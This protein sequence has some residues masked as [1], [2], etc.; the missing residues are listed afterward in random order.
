MTDTPEW[1][2]CI[3]EMLA[4]PGVV[5]VLGGSDSGK[6]TFCTELANAA[7]AAEVPCAVVD[8]DV[9]QS[10]IGPPGTIGLGIVES[11]ITTTH[12]LRPRRL[13]FVGDVT[14]VG[15][16]LQCVV[17]VK[18]LVDE[19]LHRGAKLV[20]VD[21]TGLIRGTVGARLKTYKIDLVAPSYLVAIQSA[22]EAEHVLR[23][24]RHR[25]G[26][27]I[28]RLQ[29]AAQ[30]RA[31]SQEMRSG[32]RRLRLYEHFRMAERHALRLDELDCWG[33]WLNTGEP[34]QWQEARKLEGA[35]DARV[36]HAERIGSGLYVVAGA[37]SAAARTGLALE[38]LGAK[39]IALVPAANFSGVLVGLADSVGVVI[40][41]GIVKRIDFVERTITVLSPIRSVAPIRR[42]IFG[43]LRVVEDG[44]EIG[45][46][47]AGEI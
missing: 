7:L 9:G 5:I 15:H 42:V 35:L 46:L 29:A 44:T 11:P 41:V 43:S 27:A 39:E 26:I 37:R 13:Y 4:S 24:F 23:A 36:L 14:P 20:L 6:T 10:E 12:D 21:T 30:A 8:A 28:R 38:E 3:E 1:R 22:L 34:L 40:E 47:R 31:R 25:E 16:L 2:P 17:G 33:T 18:K 32:R 45:R 19:A